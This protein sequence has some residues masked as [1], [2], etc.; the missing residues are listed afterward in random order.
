MNHLN[1]GINFVCHWIVKSEETGQGLC[2][3]EAELEHAQ[4]SRYRSP[5]IGGED[6]SERPNISRRVLVH[7]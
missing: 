1:S 4:V 3:I 2:R 7:P 6:G 5:Y